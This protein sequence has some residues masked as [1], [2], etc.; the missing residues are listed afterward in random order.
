[1]IFQNENQ[2]HLAERDS[3]E[4][5]VFDVC[6]MEESGQ[7]DSGYKEADPVEEKVVN[8]PEKKEFPE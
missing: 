5:S 2:A 8:F 6:L 4:N 1:M 7:L 3:E